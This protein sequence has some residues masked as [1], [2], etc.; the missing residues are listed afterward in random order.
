V[1]AQGGR[2]SKC[3][4]ENIAVI[5]DAVRKGLSLEA[6]CALADVGA[7]T[8]ATWM[9]GKLMRHRRFQHAVQRAKADR[10]AELVGR[11]RDIQKS[12]KESVALDALK[13]ELERQHKWSTKQAIEVS[14]PDAGPVRVEV[15]PLAALAAVA[16]AAAEPEWQEEDEGAEEGEGEP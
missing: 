9:Q 15:S 2:P 13:F 6:A 16:G 11:L 1:S 14:G 12:E 8:A 10:Q 3:T 5:A 4:P 7:R